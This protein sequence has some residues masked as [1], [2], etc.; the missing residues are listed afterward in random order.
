[1]GKGNDFEEIYRCLP[2]HRLLSPVGDDETYGKLRRLC[3]LLIGR[4]G[5]LLT[6][7]PRH[8]FSSVECQSDSLSVTGCQIFSLHNHFSCILGI[9][10]VHIPMKQL[11]F[12]LPSRGTITL[13]LVAFGILS[14]LIAFIVYQIVKAVAG[15]PQDPEER[16]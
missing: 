15:K 9:H 6:P 3:M 11:L 5:I 14:A 10:Q 13:I 12:G 4:V 8:A 16:I 1:V 7:D 2:K